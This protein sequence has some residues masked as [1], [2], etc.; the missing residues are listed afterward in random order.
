MAPS[1]IDAID[2]EEGIMT[3]KELDRKSVV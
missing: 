3:N 1:A 2:W